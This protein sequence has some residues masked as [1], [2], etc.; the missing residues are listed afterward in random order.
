MEMEVV[1]GRRKIGRHKRRWLDRVSNYIKEKG[2]SREEMYDHAT[3]RHTSTPNKSGNM[4]KRKKKKM[5]PV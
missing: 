3:L 1:Q 4:I 5:F 2:L